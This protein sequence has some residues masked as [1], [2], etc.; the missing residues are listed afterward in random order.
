MVQ[1]T[2][3]LAKDNEQR[4]QHPFSAGIFGGLTAASDLFKNIED[5][6][7][8]PT[9][10]FKESHKEKPFIDAD[11]GANLA[12]AIVQSSSFVNSNQSLSAS[13]VD[14]KL[15]DVFSKMAETAKELTDSLSKVDKAR[16]DLSNPPVAPAQAAVAAPVAVLNKPE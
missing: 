15:D 3:A 2:L 11:L 1:R 5:K 6:V 13:P 16:E 4:S 12:K 14:S 8:L 9:D 7:E 10:E